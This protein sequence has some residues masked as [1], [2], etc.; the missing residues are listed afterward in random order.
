MNE[1][2]SGADYDKAS[3]AARAATQK[4]LDSITSSVIGSINSRGVGSDD[5]EEDEEDEE[6]DD[7]LAPKVKKRTNA[8]N[9]E[10]TVKKMTKIM[11]NGS[12]DARLMAK[13]LIEEL[14]ERAAEE[15]RERR[16]E[17]R[18][19][20]KAK[21]ARERRM[22]HLRHAADYERLELPLGASKDD[23]KAAYKRL[24]VRWHPDKHP[25]GPARVAAA[26]RYADI[27]T[28]YDNLN[29]ADEERGVLAQL[30]SRAAASNPIPP[31]SKKPHQPPS[32]QDIIKSMGLRGEVLDALNAARA[33]QDVAFARAAY[34]R[35]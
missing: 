28:S 32:Q 2:F 7:V 9:A 21:R 19:K 27:R 14:F 1:G 8:P 29:S 5:S 12:G 15:K 17:D 22:F 11:I 34:H 35:S 13:K 3:Q 4:L 10:I 16:I 18:E 33:A 31:P 20:L 24:A 30:A 25:D 26:A 23:I 6:E